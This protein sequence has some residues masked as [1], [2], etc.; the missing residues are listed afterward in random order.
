MQ[1]PDWGLEMHKSTVLAAIVALIAGLHAPGSAAQF[2][3]AGRLVSFCDGTFRGEANANPT[4]YTVCL[5]YL[6]AVAD[7]TI[8]HAERGAMSP[9]ICP[10]PGLDNEALRRI[11]L[12]RVQQRPD[13]WEVSASIHALDAFSNAWPCP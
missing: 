1:Q 2:I 12:E 4:F 11:F 6:T 7:A 10:P 3:T 8:T 13:E 5:S 9:Q